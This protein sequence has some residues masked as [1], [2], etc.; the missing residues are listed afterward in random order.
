[1]LAALSPM[2]WPVAGNK[3]IKGWS[4][5]SNCPAVSDSESS[6]A[7]EFVSSSGNLGPIANDSPGMSLS[8]SSA[9]LPAALLSAVLFSVAL[10]SCDSESLFV[11]PSESP[12]VPTVLPVESGFSVLR[13]VWFPDCVPSQ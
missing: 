3:A 12:L 10:P 2:A 6:A 1:M 8:D 13:A 11:V 9:S 4:S 7:D 5:P